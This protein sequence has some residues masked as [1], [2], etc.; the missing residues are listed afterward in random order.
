MNNKGFTLIEVLAVIVLL[1]IIM[2]IAA[3]NIT[4]QINRK[5]KEEQNLLNEKI[6][7]ASMLYVSKYY[8]DDILSSSPNTNII[9]FTLKDLQEDGLININKNGNCKNVI[10]KDIIVYN[11]DNVIK[12]DYSNLE[13]CYK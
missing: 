13:N 11:F 9:S 4:K 1:V 10:S 3:P 7:N 12:Y 5:E 2:V 8:L 6:E